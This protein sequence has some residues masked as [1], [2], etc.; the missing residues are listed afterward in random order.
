MIEMEDVIKI[1]SK[2]LVGISIGFL[3]RIS[4]SALALNPIE[5]CS[6]EKNK[7]VDQGYMCQVETSTGN[8]FWQLD[9]KTTSGKMVW[10]DLKSNFLVS[11]I[12]DEKYTHY[13]AKDI[14]TDNSSLEARGNL[15]TVN[16]GLPSGYPKV[17]NGK[18][19]FPDKDSDFETL[20]ANGIRK[21]IDTSG[22]YFWSSSV[23]PSGYS[24]YA[25]VF[26]GNYG[27]IDYYGRAYYYGS[28]LCIGR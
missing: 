23:H 3:I 14:C 27:T 11:D 17:L 13:Q 24:Y 12:L 1:K 16:W 6:L 25:F 4:N 9:T 22:R 18:K 19:G 15:T 28:V 26:D 7:T 2:W 21:V 10:R 8:V 5:I 20:E